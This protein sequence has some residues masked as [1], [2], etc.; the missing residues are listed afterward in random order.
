MTQIYKSTFQ[1]QAKGI[2]SLL[3]VAP[4]KTERN[5]AHTSGTKSTSA[6]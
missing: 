6:T 3:S 1:R 2:N 5:V 4:V